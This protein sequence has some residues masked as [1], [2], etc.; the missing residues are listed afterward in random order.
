M[1]V[2]AIVGVGAVGGTIAAHL[3]AA[4]RDEVVLCVRTPF[5]AL[6][7]EG[8]AGTLRA[9]PRLV[10]TPAT[11]EPVPWV[12]LATKAHQ[13]AGAA[14]WLQAPVTSHTTVAILQNALIGFRGLLLQQRPR[15]AAHFEDH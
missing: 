7:V 13:T 10:T 11:V 8:S 6:V 15:N 9:T 3:C 5:E 2:V 12:L 1:S 14:A 4:G